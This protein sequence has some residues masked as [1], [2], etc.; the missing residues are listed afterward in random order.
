VSLAPAASSLWIETTPATDY[1]P[2]GAGVEVDVAVAGGGIA[3][4][5]T[6]YLLKR[7]GRTVALLESK[8]IVHGASGYTT[9]KVTAGHGLTY[10]P[11]EQRLGAEAAG[12]YAEAQ[13]RGLELLRQLVGDEGIDCE[14]EERANY[15]LAETSDEASRVHDEV[16]AARRAGLP[17]SSPPAD[18][19]GVPFPITG[20][21]RLDGQAQ[22][23]PRRYLLALAAR[24]PGQGSHV[25]E[26]TRVL[27][28]DRDRPLRVSTDRGELLAGDLVL[29]THLPILDRG[30][31]FAKAHPTRSYAVAARLPA[32]GLPDGMFIN[33]GS[34]TRSLRTARDADGPLLIVG[35]EGHRPGEEE[36]TGRRYQ[37]LELFAGLWFGAEEFPYRWAT[38]DYSPVDGVPYV[39]R[40]GMGERHVWVATGFKK[41]GMTNGT[42]AAEILADGILTNPNR[43]SRLFDAERV[44]ARVALPR[45]L[46]E[47]LV[48]ARHFVVDRVHRARPAE[49]D[50]LA[51]GEGRLVSRRGRRTAVYRDESG[52][53]HTLSPVCTHLGCHVAWNRAERT[54]DCPCHG[55]RFSGEGS[56]IQGP[57]VRD[58]EPRE[59]PDA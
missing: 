25:F 3:G 35:G 44:N 47:N 12:L 48:V 59:L 53:V 56:V 38:Q 27:G 19:V 51:P 16:E 46:Q 55:S 36:D 33:V 26:Q 13:T 21:F 31:F 17:A 10:A 57:A 23:H 34:P 29:A 39:G 30:L 9:A 8:R 20:A 50:E 58:L 40:L 14:L 52:F 28:V 49:L 43:F 45:L 15:V 18:D 42:V 41:W 1:P 37:A 2:L 6:A 7:A 24:I 22:F 4:I 32:D 5:T 11:L 54:W